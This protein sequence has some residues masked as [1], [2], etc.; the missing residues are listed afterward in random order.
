[1]AFVKKVRVESLWRVANSFLGKESLLLI[2]MAG[3]AKTV[4]AKSAG[5]EASKAVAD[6]LTAAI[7]DAIE[8]TIAAR[9][10]GNRP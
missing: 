5:W 1:L 4:A 6:R 9:E 8:A 2:P 3:A 10:Q 7:L